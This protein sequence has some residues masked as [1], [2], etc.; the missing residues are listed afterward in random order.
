MVALTIYLV[1]DIALTK[2]RFT[3]VSILSPLLYILEYSSYKE[4]PKDS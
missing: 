4:K 3:K 1:V 2:S